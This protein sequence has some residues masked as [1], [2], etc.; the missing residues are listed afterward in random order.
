MFDF[1]NM[2]TPYINKHC[3]VDFLSGGGDSLGPSA[4]A[5]IQAYADGQGGYEFVSTPS[6]KVF[7]ILN[8]MTGTSQIEGAIGEQP[9][10]YNNVD[11]L[12]MLPSKDEM[13][14][15][16]VTVVNLKKEEGTSTRITLSVD[17]YELEGKDIEV[18]TVDGDRFDAMNTLADKDRVVVDKAA[19]VNSGQNISYDLKP[20]SVTA[21]KIPAD[22]QKP[23]VDTVKLEQSIQENKDRNPND[24]TPKTWSALQ[25]ALTQAI[26][27]LKSDEQA[28]IDK[29]ADELEQ[30]A[31][32]LVRRADVSKLRKAYDN[33]KA[34]DF[35]KYTEESGQ[36]VKAIFAEAEAMLSDADAAQAQVDEL[37]AR[38]NRAVNGLIPLPQ[39]P[40]PVPSKEVTSIKLIGESKTLG[41]KEGLQL[42]Y[43][44][45]PAGASPGKM[46]WK[47]SNQKVASVNAKGKVTARRAGKTTITVITANGKKNTYKI[48]VKKA[49]AKLT[50]KANKKTMKAGK[51]LQL[52]KALSKGSAGKV[53]FKSSN[54]KVATV[55]A[56]GK[57]KA[58]RNGR[59]TITARTYNGRKASVKLTVLKK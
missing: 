37:E 45:K 5:V 27:A 10:F 21:F 29:A 13:G 51:T 49:P 23:P 54:K 24:Y 22:K 50:L 42:K 9:K 36:A 57:V 58:L 34:I 18:W 11:T 6:A 14:N 56:K 25:S 8:H 16:Y 1:V 12:S 30:A 43:T 41:V 39:T 59:V 32:A 19:F 48:T 28:V 35:G 20:H 44:V 26:E 3:L 17:G 2:E 46:T 31:K 4:Q 15:V 38:L 53:T 33:A 52:K 47:S 55:N 7:E 40:D